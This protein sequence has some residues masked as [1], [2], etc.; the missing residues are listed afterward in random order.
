VKPVVPAIVRAFGSALQ[1]TLDR[2]LVAVY[3]G[4]SYSMDDFVPGFSDYDLMVIVDRPLAP[5]DL[6]RVASAHESIARLPE[7]ERLEGDYVPRDWLV[8]SGTTQPVDWFRSGRLQPGREFM[9]S[10]DNIANIR[11]QGI[12]IV[13]PLPRTL[14]PQPTRDEVRAAVRE[15]LAD[16]ELPATEAKAADEI[17]ALLRSM[18]ALETGKPTTKSEGLHWGIDHVDPRWLDVI[19]FADQVRRGE[20][21]DESRT[22]LRAALAELRR[23]LL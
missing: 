20:R 3:L 4:G 5:V 1:Q 12:A 17:L 22:T 14:L 19:R 9:L 23:A 21:V 2:D 6:T 16:D 15:M 11:S 7:F 13:G 8:S 10:A 18:R